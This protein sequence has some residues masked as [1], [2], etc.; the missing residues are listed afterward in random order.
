VT[1]NIVCTHIDLWDKF[2]EIVLYVTIYIAVVSVKIEDEIIGVSE[3]FTVM[4]FI[5]FMIGKKIVSWR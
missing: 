5:A 1:L 4:N 3:P 2:K